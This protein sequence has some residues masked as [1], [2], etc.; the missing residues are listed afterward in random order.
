M[1]TPTMWPARRE[2]R[3]VAVARDMTVII[4]RL[5]SL[6]I[7]ISSL[8]A[9]VDAVA[10]CGTNTYQKITDDVHQEVHDIS[11]H[12]SRMELL[13]FRTS[14]ENDAKVDAEIAELVPSTRK[15]DQIMK[16]LGEIKPPFVPRFPYGK[17][18]NRSEGQEGIELEKQS[19]NLEGAAEK[20]KHTRGEY[21]E[22]KNQNTELAVQKLDQEVYQERQK[23]EE[24]LSHEKQKTEKELM[25]EKQ[26]TDEESNHEKQ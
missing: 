20:V 21:T 5:E 1:A 26:V 16:L 17:I 12:I 8:T 6:E 3:Q 14:L 22:P 13:P 25:P 11:A 18:S 2:K 23:I 10:S 4:H 15:A 19:W 7:A 24:H 9:K